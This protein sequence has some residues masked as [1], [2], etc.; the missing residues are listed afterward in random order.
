MQTNFEMETETINLS[1]PKKAFLSGIDH[2]Y[3]QEAI[4]A[5]LFYNGTLTLKQARLLIGKS[6]REFEEDILPKFG[7]TTMRNNPDNAE[8]EISSATSI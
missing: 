8:V 4:A 7:Y 1:I 2:F 3:F 5:V 6:R